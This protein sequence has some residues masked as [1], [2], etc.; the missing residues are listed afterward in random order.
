M[1][2]RIIAGKHTVKNEDGTRTRFAKGSVIESDKP[3]DE[4]HENKFEK[5]RDDEETSDPEAVNQPRNTKSMKTQAEK[6]EA[7]EK[8]EAELSTSVDEAPSPAD[9]Q[10]E[11]DDEGKEAEEGGS[12][13]E[14]DDGDQPEITL[15]AIHR[16]RG[17]WDVVKVINGVETEE[18]VNEAFLKKAAAK[19]MEEAGW[20]IP[21]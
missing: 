21:E 6:R 3:L 12:A 11:E 20:P 10:A 15:K 8:E 16:G 19:E 5:V 2:F 4:I 17:N 18:N 14:D 13:D 7:R 1:K 9:E